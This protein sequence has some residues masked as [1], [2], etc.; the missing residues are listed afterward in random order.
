MTI[1]L[2]G[3][4]VAGTSAGNPFFVKS[5]GTPHETYPFDKVKTEHFMPAF[6]KGFKLQEAEIKAIDAN[7][8]K[9]DFSNTIE[10]LERSGALLHDVSAV[11]YTLTGSENNDELMALSA[12]VAEMQTIHSNKINLDEKLFERVKAVYDNRNNL[13]LTTEQSKL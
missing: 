12:K 8:A 5:Y 3:S 10:A 4:A 7:K 6:E 9:P 13:S 1:A 11:F 2:A